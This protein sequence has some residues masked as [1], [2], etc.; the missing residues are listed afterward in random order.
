MLPAS[1]D[2]GFQIVRED[3]KLRRPTVVIGTKTDD[4]YLVT[5]DAKIGEKS[6]SKKRKFQ[7]PEVEEDFIPV[8]SIRSVELKRS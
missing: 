2:S 4:V 1:L 6:E 8:A 7:P 5:A 3:Q